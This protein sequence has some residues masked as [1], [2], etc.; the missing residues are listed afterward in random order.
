MAEP[1]RSREELEKRRG[2]ILAE[3]GEVNEDAR[4][5]LDNDM[6]EQAIQMEQH[7]VAVTMEENLRKELNEIEDKLAEMEEEK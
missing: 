2:E 3:L 6:E 7:E 4:I 1:K 5:E